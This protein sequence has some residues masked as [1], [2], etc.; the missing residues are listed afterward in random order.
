MKR[1]NDS[2]FTIVELM[3]AIAIFGVIGTVLTNVMMLGFRSYSDTTQRYNESNDRQFL[4]TWLTRDVQSATTIARTG[5]TCGASS[6]TTILRLTWNESSA[7]APPAVSAR[8]VTYRFTAGV[9]TVNGTLT[10]VLCVNSAVTTTVVV[11]RWLSPGTTSATSTCLTA[12]LVEDLTCPA[13][14][15]GARLKLTESQASFSIDGIR[16]TG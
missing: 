8:E 1:D 14:S 7:A 16:R 2:G 6:G 13:T 4:A 12:A 10:R 5:G 9:G 15:R 3:V 11:A